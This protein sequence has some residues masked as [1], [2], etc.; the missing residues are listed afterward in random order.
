MARTRI[1]GHD[2][3][4]FDEQGHSFAFGTNSSLSIETAMQAVSDK[5]SSIYQNQEPSEIS[6]NITSDH[7][8]DMEEYYKFFDYQNSKQK[9]KVWYG[10]RKGYKGGPDQNNTTYGM[11][12]EVNNG[13]DGYREIEPTS[14]ALCGYVYV[15]SINQTASNGDRANYSVQLQGTGTLSKVKFS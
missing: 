7:T 13:A 3:M 15:Q 1:E 5:D 6:W 4:L 14:Y 2:I 12:T 9:I 10:L 11:T 8:M